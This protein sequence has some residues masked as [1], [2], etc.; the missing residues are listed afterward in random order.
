MLSLIIDTSRDETTLLLV[1]DD[2]VVGAETLTAEIRHSR[3]LLSHIDALLKK[4]HI[5]PNAL[6]S[7]GISI[8]PGAFTGTR[9]GVMCAKTLAYALHTPLISYLS[10]EAYLPTADGP[11]GVLMDAKAD[12]FYLLRGTKDKESVDYP[13]PPE[14][15]T[16]L[17]EDIPLYTPDTALLNKYP[18]IKP[19]TF[20]KLRIAR[21]IYERWKKGLTFK[22][23]QVDVLYLRS[24]V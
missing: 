13:T 24:P 16:S 23:D 10:L 5:T 20:H 14:L 18:A 11:F 19:V 22:H 15:I 17:P 4:F 3:Y 8:G 9:I 1:S 2:K 12:S 7:I 6:T 21:L